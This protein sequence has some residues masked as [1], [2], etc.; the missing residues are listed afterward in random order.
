MI[1]VSVT[2]ENIEQGTSDCRDCPIARAIVE[3]L[4]VNVYEMRARV[5]V[6]EYIEIAWVL[7][8]HK[9]EIVGHTDASLKFLKDFDAGLPVKPFEFE[10]DI[11]GN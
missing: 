3:A 7:P 4:F 6:G 1:K 5:S 10:L 11:V 8:S 9:R 2:Q